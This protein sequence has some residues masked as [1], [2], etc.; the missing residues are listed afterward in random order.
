MKISLKQ[1]LPADISN[2][3]AFQL[4]KFIHGLSLA[5]ESIYFD[6]MLQYTSECEHYPFSEEPEGENDNPF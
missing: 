5:L 3:A 4:V 2:E 1:L 6:Q